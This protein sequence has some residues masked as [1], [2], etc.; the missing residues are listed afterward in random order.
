MYAYLV[1]NETYPVIVNAS[2]TNEELERLIV[3]LKRN[4]NAIT[5]SIDDIKGISPSIC[6][7]KNFMNEGNKLVRQPQKKLNPTLKEVVR[8]EVLKLLKAGIIYPISDSEWVSP[9]QF[10]PLK[11][12]ITVIISEANELLPSRL[13]MGWRMCID[14]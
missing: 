2:L 5:W 1:E 6:M 13:V 14:F 7:Q 10:V 12:G 4:K 8:K 3:V 11:S 9:T